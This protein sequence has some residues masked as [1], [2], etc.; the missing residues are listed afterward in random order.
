[1]SGVRVTLRVLAVLLAC[2]LLALGVLVAVEV[3]LAALGRPAAVLPYSRLADVLRE[4]T[5]QAGVVRTA[6][7]GLCLL[8]LLVVLPALRRGKPSDLPLQAVTDGVDTAVDRRGLQKTLAA[9]AERV[10]GVRSVTAKVGRRKVRVR[11]KSRLRDTTGLPQQIDQ[12]VRDELDVLA[13]HQPLAVKVTTKK[14]T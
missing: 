14:R 1:M 8:G 12:A 13:L 11:A 2:G 10:D 4:Q 9:A 7:L 6:G 3:V 5:W